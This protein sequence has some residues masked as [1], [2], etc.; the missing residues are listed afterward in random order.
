MALEEVGAKRLGTTLRDKWVLEQLIGVGGMASVYIGRHKIGRREAIKILHAEIAKSEQIRA[1]FEQE[2]LAVNSFRHPGVVEVRDVDVTEDGAP[3]LVMELLEGESLSDR[4]RRE[5]PLTPLDVLRLA[6]EVLDVLAAAHERQIVHRDIKPDNLFVQRDG[7]IKVLDFGIARMRSGLGI[8]PRTQAGVT[9]GTIAYMPPEQARGQ[10]IDGR[11]DL[12]AL[13]AT[14]FRVLAGRIVHDASTDAELVIKAL[15]DPAPR[16]ATLAPGVPVAIASIVDRALAYDRDHR[17]PNAAAM[18]EDVAAVLCGEPPPYASAAPPL[19]ERAPPSFP[20]ASGPAAGS[21][22][23]DAA[24][25]VP[26]AKNIQASTPGVVAAPAAAPAP[27]TVHGAP[28]RIGVA[29]EV[30]PT[31]LTPQGPVPAAA[32]PTRMVSSPEPS[33]PPIQ[34]R[35]A[36][37]PRGFRVPLG[38]IV[39]VAALIVLLFGA[40]A[41]AVCSGPRETSEQ[42]AE[43]SPEPASPA[44]RP[45]GRSKGDK[46]DKD[47]NKE[48]NKK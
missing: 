41:F 36:P 34:I 26:R 43:P 48:K 13:G 6:G 2:A 32:M 22:A 1:R 24:T 46:K 45:P 25:F 38:A 35:P 42:V 11:A 8:A 28:T 27:G 29:P 39:A 15:S 18:R 12:Y 44:P 3:F 37:L 20:F 10:E 33:P 16:L 40:L 31:R 7:K 14:M 30:A 23:R 21:A 19:P 17:Y 5:P 47:D 9:L 4:V